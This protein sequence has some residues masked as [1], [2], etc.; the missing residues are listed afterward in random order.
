ME[1]GEMKKIWLIYDIFK[2]IVELFNIKAT[3]ALEANE[4]GVT[5]IAKKLKWIDIKLN[6]KMKT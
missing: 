4:R 2:Y 3:K 6:L 1:N 5:N